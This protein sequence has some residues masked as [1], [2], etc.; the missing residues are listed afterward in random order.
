MGLS[1]SQLPAP[2]LARLPFPLE[3]L[4]AWPGMP[5]LS[6]VWLAP[7][8][9]GYRGVGLPEGPL[10]TALHL[11]RGWYAAQ[12]RALPRGSHHNGTPLCAHHTDSKGC[13]LPPANSQHF[14]GQEGL[15]LTVLIFYQV[16][17]KNGNVFSHNS[18]V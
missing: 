6:P 14:L 8:T 15:G 3:P 16:A 7:V 9:S 18:G 10:M 13:C 17:S 11:E 12:R 5:S 2:W 1:G 4:L